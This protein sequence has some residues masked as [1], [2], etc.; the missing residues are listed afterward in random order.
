MN[1]KIIDGLKEIRKG[2]DTLLEEA[3]DNAEEVKCT[4]SEVSES[5][6]VSSAEKSS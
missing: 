5:V 1:A 2:I 4:S 6:S 3:I